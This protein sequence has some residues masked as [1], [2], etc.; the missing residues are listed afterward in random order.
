MSRKLKNKL[1]IFIAITLGILGFSLAPVFCR[2]PIKTVQKSIMIDP[3]HGGSD[4]GIVSKYDY[5]EKDITLKLAVLL[6]GL[7][8][9]EYQVFLTR[10]SDSAVDIHSRTSAANIRKADLF[11][12]IH[13]NNSI[14]D[15]GMFYYYTPCSHTDPPDANHQW[16]WHRQAESHIDASRSLCTV[17]EKEYTANFTD[18]PFHTISAPVSVLQGCQMPA[19][20]AEPFSLKALPDSDQAA[21]V[22]MRQQAGILALTIRSFLKN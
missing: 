17:L 9:P 6:A 18:K 12:S 15:Q 2:N 16:L 10:S 1:C 5:S 14:P 21:D 19:I 22:W 20:M 4:T 7:L 13:I 8:E 11:I 3:G